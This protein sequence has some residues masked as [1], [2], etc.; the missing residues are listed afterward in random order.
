MKLSKKILSQILLFMA[1]FSI[2]TSIFNISAVAA[3]LPNSSTL[4]ANSAC[5]AVGGEEGI[6]TL[7]NGKEG[8]VG[9]II[10]VAQIVTYISGALAVLF[11]VYGGV[12][13]LT[14]DEK[15]LLQLELSSRMRL[16]V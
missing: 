7:S 8:V 9:V 15:V 13:Y 12:K 16:L 14:A 1:T 3:L 5:E 6:R 10:Q 4:C 11:L 2:F